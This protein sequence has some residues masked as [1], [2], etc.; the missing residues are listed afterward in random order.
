M[1]AGGK[2]TSRWAIFCNFFLKKKATLM[3]LDSIR[4]FSAEPFKR[5]RFLAFESQLE[6]IKLFNPSFTYNL[7]PKHV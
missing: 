6:K 4:T 7:S 1:G 2:A 3:P 5:T